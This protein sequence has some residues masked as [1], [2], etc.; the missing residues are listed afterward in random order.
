VLLE[1]PNDEDKLHKVS[2]MGP[3][4]LRKKKE[5][6]TYQVMAVSVS[7]IRCPLRCLL[8]ATPLPP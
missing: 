3:G 8:L 6:M 2:R 1:Q 4:R 5:A 7:P